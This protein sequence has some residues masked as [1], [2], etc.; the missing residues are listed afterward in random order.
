MSPELIAI[1]SVG[2]GLGGLL[3][4]LMQQARNDARQLRADLQQSR[5][6]A[7]ADV[8]QL[9]VDVRADVQQLRADVQADVQQLRGDLQQLRAE[10]RALETRVAGVEQGQARLEGVIDGLREAISGRG[11]PAA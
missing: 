4:T 8:Q 3:V 6:D 7:Q 9:R 1:L 10:V 2:V 5:A 11:Q